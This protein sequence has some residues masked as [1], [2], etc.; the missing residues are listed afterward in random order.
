MTTRYDMDDEL[1]TDVIKGMQY[2]ALAITDDKP[3]TLKEVGKMNPWHIEALKVLTGSEEE[4]HMPLTHILAK[5]ENLTCD[6]ILD[7]SGSTPGGGFVDTQGYIAH[8]D[9]AIVLAFRCTTSFYDWLTNFDTTSS[10]WEIAEDAEKGFS[11]YCSSLEGLAC[12]GASHKPRVHTGFYNNFLAILPELREHIDPLL[13]ADQPP[14][15]LYVVGHSLGAGIANM[16]ACYY[17]LQF[18]WDQIPHRLVT[19]TAGSPRSVVTSMRDLMNEQLELY[20]HAKTAMCRVVRN[21][22]VVTTVPPAIL[23]FRHMGR[24]VYI[25]EDNQVELEVE[26][27]DDEEKESGKEEP[28]DHMA[29]KGIEPH[30]DDDEEDEETPEGQPKMT[31]YEKKV[32]RIPVPFRD[33]MPDFYLKPM[34]IAREELFPI[35]ILVSE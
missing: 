12:C 35:E 13:A 7:K 6:A 17:L 24:L 1:T 30:E 28:I 9:E 11:G 5:H 32:G 20:G 4:A 10:D 21:K 34:R 31:Q 22:D 8:N 3:D 23:G 33:H 15:K 16:A 25:T 2:A 27:N 29:F 19:V 26:D 18:Q 14:R